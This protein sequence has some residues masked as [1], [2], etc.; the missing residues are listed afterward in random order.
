[1]NKGSGVLIVVI[2]A[3]VFSIYIGSTFVQNEHLDIMTKKYE[4]NIKIIYEYGDLEDIY[5]SLG[6]I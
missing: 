4:D 5:K 3:I 2:S 6:G 1:M